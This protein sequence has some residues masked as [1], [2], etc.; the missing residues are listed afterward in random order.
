MRILFAAIIFSVAACG[1]AAKK[2]WIAHEADLV[3]VGTFH[4]GL[5]YPWIDGWYVAGI[6]DVNETLDG[7]QVG[8]QIEYRFVCRWDAMCRHWPPPRFSGFFTQIGIWFPRSV[9]R[10]TWGPP[11]IGGTDPGFRTLSERAD[12]E[13]Y[14]RLYKR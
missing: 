7:P 10:Q 12:F 4:H 1:R 9:N 11:G 8:R 13:N 5:T 2:Y 6:V 3:V 14:I